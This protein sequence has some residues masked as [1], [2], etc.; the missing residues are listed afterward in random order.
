MAGSPPRSQMI[1]VD[2][3]RKT[4]AA[5]MAVDDVSF[6]VEAGEVFGVI[7]PNGAGKTTVV[8]CISGL[9]APDGGPVRV[10]AGGGAGPRSAARPGPAIHRSRCRAGRAKTLGAGPCSRD[11][12]GLP[13]R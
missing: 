7:G 9:R 10:L 3:L 4:Y 8:E 1:V 13:R 6:A 2:R 5:A 12:P 11:P